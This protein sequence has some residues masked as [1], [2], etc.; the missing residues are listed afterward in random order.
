M[1]IK[2]VIALILILSSFSAADSDFHNLT[3]EKSFWTYYSVDETFN[4]RSNSINTVL[5]N[6]SDVV[7]DFLLSDWNIAEGTERYAYLDTQNGGEWLEEYSQLEKGNYYSVR[8]HL[9]LYDAGN[10]TLVQA[11]KEFWNWFTLRHEVTSNEK[12]VIELEEDLRNHNSSLRK[13]YVGNEGILDS[14]GWITII[15]ISSILIVFRKNFK[16]FYANFEQIK[17][18]APQFKIFSSILSIFVLVNL[19][20]VILEPSLDINNHVITFIFYPILVIALPLLTYYY[21]SKQ[22]VKDFYSVLIAFG[23]AFLVDSLYFQTSFVPATY[24][25]Q[26]GGFALLISFLPFIK[27]RKYVNKVYI[28]LWSL[29]YFIWLYSISAGLI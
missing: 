18:L 14:T 23:L 13:E 20:P 7:N 12:A 29:F 21:S 11:H 28:G 3:D 2:L 5:E 4:G 26:F 6:E 27:H 10:Y 22:P 25:L 24:L 1:K 9:R 16:Q 19:F 17:T 8:K 15:S